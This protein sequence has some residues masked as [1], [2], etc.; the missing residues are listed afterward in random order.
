MNGWKNYA[1]AIVGAVIAA[2]TALSTALED[3]V[4][5]YQEWV[6]VAL[7]LLTGLAVIWAVPNAA[8]QKVEE[9]P[10]DELETPTGLSD[11]GAPDDDSVEE[12]ADDLD[13]IDEDI[14]SE[15]QE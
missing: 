6:T 4:V 1:K 15:P 13:L 3:G 11:D 2:L 10:A 14:V 12:Q 9:I 5:S 8:E 7:G